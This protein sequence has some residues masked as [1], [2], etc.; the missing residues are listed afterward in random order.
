MRS[1][2]VCCA[3]ALC[4]Q[5]KLEALQQRCKSSIP[6]SACY[7]AIVHVE[8]R[9]HDSHK[10]RYPLKRGEFEGARFASLS[11]NYA[12]TATTRYAPCG[13]LLYEPLLCKSRASGFL[14]LTCRLTSE[15][16]LVS[17]DNP[18]NARRRHYD[19]E[20]IGFLEGSCPRTRRWVRVLMILGI[21]AQR[22]GFRGHGVVGRRLLCLFQ[23]WAHGSA[24]CF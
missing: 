20:G 19:D 6:H 9:G 23:V 18:G 22:T 3:W 7:I 5:P 8:S 24:R 11:L 21:W 1:F 10:P 14:A 13:S 17:V 2:C 15:T 12:L 16:R 4:L